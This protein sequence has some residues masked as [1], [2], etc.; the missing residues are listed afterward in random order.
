MTL[1]TWLDHPAGDWVGGIAA[2]TC[3]YLLSGPSGPDVGH[4]AVALQTLTEVSLG[5]L[6]VGIVA[7]T[8]IFSVTPNTRLQR[9]FN[10]V[11]T[12]LR[13][14]VTSSLAGLF[15][16]TVGF[17]VLLVLNT[18]GQ[19]L[20]GAGAFFGALAALRFIRLFWIF[21]RILHALM[22]RVDATPGGDDWKRPTVSDG[23]YEVP[24]RQ[25]T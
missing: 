3:A 14:I 16:A 23:D 25:V 24:R 13:R 5:L 8:L 21:S 9:V 15:V 4:R 10:R 7:V 6:S 17:V 1:D 12:R 18:R 19:V 2:A 11:G 22:L 20:A